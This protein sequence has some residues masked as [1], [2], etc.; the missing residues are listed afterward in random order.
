MRTWW[1]VGA[2]LV[3]TAQANVTPTEANPAPQRP[4]VRA[5]D[6]NELV[7]VCGRRGCQ[8]VALGNLMREIQ[9]ERSGGGDIIG[10]G[11]GLAEQNFTYALTQLAD[12]IQEAIKEGMVKAED[13]EQLKIIGR[14]ARLEAEKSD[15]LVFVSGRNNPGLFK[16]ADSG[17]VRLA[18]TGLSADTPIL[19]NLDLLYSKQPDGESEMLPLPVMVASLVHELG[20]NVG[21]KDHAYLDFLGARVRRMIEREYNRVSRQL[22]SGPR[23]EMVSINLGGSGL[24]RLNLMVDETLVPF[25]QELHQA[26]KC[27]NGSL[28]RSAR[29]SNQHWEKP[30]DF[31]GRWVTPYRAWLALTC[32]SEQGRAVLEERDL[33]LDL[34]IDTS[35]EEVSVQLVQMGVQN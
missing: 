4:T 35:G 28:P 24:P 6:P 3:G 1:M 30:V 33:V 14:Q 8:S 12:F 13:A 5:Y 7:Q 23:V 29:M 26:L 2:L 11:G 10:N 21:L 16:S 18:T 9:L 17:E 20:H 27:R 25:E 32:V 31:S 19:V 15:K 22:G 34:V